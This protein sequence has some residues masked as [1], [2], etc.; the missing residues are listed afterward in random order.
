MTNSGVSARNSKFDFFNEISEN[1]LINYPF[2]KM[3]RFISEIEKRAIIEIK[4]ENP[5]FTHKR[6][7]ECF[8]EKFKVVEYIL[9]L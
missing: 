9:K 4:S 8:Y 2:R 3:S 6:I 1:N 5:N 7:A